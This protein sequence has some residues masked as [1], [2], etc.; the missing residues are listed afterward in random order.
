MK[1]SGICDVTYWGDC[2]DLRTQDGR[3]FEIRVDGYRG[4]K[5]FDGMKVHVKIVDN[6][7]RKFKLA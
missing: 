6:I 2:V 7:I 3:T 1:F 4:L 5:A